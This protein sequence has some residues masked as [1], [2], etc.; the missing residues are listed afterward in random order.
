[1]TQT[2]IAGLRRQAPHRSRCRQQPHEPSHL[3]SLS[4]RQLAGP[5]L[6]TGDVVILD[7]FQVDERQNAFKAADMSKSERP[8]L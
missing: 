4:R 6:A 1:M 5:T 8:T 3:R 7:I 2:F